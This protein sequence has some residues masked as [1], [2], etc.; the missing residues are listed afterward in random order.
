MID[1]IDIV[2]DEMKSKLVMQN[3]SFKWLVETSIER[4]GLIHLTSLISSFMFHYPR[5]LT[6]SYFWGTVMQ[7]INFSS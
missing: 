4:E 7:A 5:S 3:V 2:D 6:G 1:G